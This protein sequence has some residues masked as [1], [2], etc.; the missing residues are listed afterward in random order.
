MNG[1][2]QLQVLQEYVTWTLDTSSIK[3]ARAIIDKINLAHPRPLSF[4]QHVMEIEKVEYNVS[5]D[6]T[7]IN[8]CFELI[9]DSSPSDISSFTYDLSLE[10]WMEH[11]AFEMER[12]E[13]AKAAQLFWKAEKVVSDPVELQ[14]RYQLIK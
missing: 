12:G 7:R 9:H 3:D 1:D 11:I 10:S 4:H 13:Y 8:K 2:V 6:V 14:R 5:K